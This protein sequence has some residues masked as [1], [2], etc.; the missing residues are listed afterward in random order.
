[1]DGFPKPENSERTMVVI[2]QVEVGRHHGGGHHHGGGWRGG[3]GGWG[4]W[5]W[6]WP[7]SYYPYAYGGG[8]RS[9]HKT[10]RMLD[11]I[12][13]KLDRLDEEEHRQKGKGKRK[14]DS[15]DGIPQTAMERAQFLMTH[16]VGPLVHM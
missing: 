15:S 1:M 9:E 4:G 7:Y 6:G 3:G 10:E 8:G 5:G 11:A 12:E 2:G 14:H 13:E 16:G